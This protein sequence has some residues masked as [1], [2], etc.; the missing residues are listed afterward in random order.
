MKQKIRVVIMITKFIVCQY[1]G[2]NPVFIQ[3]L[4]KYFKIMKQYLILVLI[5]L[6]TLDSTKISR[7]KSLLQGNTSARF[8]CSF[9]ICVINTVPFHL[10]LKCEKGSTLQEV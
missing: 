4:N 7:V 10:K 1:F 9:L 3:R 6:G 8:F 2:G 5:L